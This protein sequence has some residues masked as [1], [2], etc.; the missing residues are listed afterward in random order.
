MHVDNNAEQNT[1]LLKPSLAVNDDANFVTKA[2]PIDNINGKSNKMEL[3]S[4]RNYLTNHIK[5]KSCH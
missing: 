1:V 3:K 2:K 5:L 4:S